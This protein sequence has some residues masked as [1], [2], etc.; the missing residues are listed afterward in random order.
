M[1]RKLDRSAIGLG[2]VNE[3]ANRSC[4]VWR[5]TYLSRPD[6]ETFLPLPLLAS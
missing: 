5:S 4:V 3:P 1:M 6:H 2:L